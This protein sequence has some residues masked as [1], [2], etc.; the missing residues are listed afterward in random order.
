MARLAKCIRIGQALAYGHGCK[1]DLG[2]CRDDIGL[3]NTL[4]W[5]AVDLERAGNEEQAGRQ[6]LEEDDSLATELASKED[7]DGARCDG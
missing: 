5:H 6:L 3:V 2:A 4:Q 7:E 1:V